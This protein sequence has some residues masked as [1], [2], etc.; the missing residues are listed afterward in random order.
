MNLCLLMR[1]L[2]LNYSANIICPFRPQSPW[3]EKECYEIQNSPQR[4]KKQVIWRWDSQIK[5]WLRPKTSFDRKEEYHKEGWQWKKHNFSKPV[6]E[7]WTIINQDED[8]YAN[9][10]DRDRIRKSLE[11]SLLDEKQSLQTLIEQRKQTLCISRLFR[12]C[13]GKTSGEFYRQR[14]LLDLPQ[15]GQRS[16]NIKPNLP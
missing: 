16:F 13:I 11:F 5:R 9:I 6:K 4:L 3:K 1:L 10:F 8:R 2:R 15:K 12:I 7:L 14:R